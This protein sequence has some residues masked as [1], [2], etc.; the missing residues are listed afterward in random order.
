MCPWSRETKVDN[1]CYGCDGQVADLPH[2]MMIYG[3][4]LDWSFY[5]LAI[6]HHFKGR[7]LEVSNLENTHA[8]LSI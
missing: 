6:C 7:W 8:G 2:A 4:G 5:S 1:F 3:E